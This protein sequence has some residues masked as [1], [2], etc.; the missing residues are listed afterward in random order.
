MAQIDSKTTFSLELNE[1]ETQW[2]Y[3]IVKDY[4]Q[5]KNACVVDL[6]ETL[7]HALLRRNFFND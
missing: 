6:E 3:R 1:G 7:K 2:L 5:Y 4:A